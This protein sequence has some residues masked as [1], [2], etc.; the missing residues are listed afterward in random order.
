METRVLCSASDSH[1]EHADTGR[2]TRK[3]GFSEKLDRGIVGLALCR[4]PELNPPLLR[5]R[6]NSLS[7]VS[8]TAQYGQSGPSVLRPSADNLVRPPHSPVQSRPSRL[9]PRVS[10]EADVCPLAARSLW[11]YGRTLLR[12]GRLRHGFARA[13]CGPGP[14]T[15]SL[16]GRQRQHA[17]G[18][19][20]VHTI[21][22]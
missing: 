10:D 12:S 15:H 20:G 4:L 18:S 11:F 19:W 1:L 16:P 13:G 14:L 2:D 6:S 8:S 9:S 7:A 3:S 21:N 22:G 5:S 17:I